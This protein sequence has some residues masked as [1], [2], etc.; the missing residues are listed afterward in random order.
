MT[1]RRRGLGRGLDALLKVETPGVQALPLE[2]LKPNRLQPRERFDGADLDELAESIRA[3]G[4]VQPIVITPR[5]DGDYTIVAGERRWRAARRAGLEQVPV[6]VREISDD[7]EL[8][9]MA[10]V[11]NLQRT[12]LNPMEEAEA[13]SRLQGEF[14]LSQEEVAIRVGKARPSVSNAVRLLRLPD[15]VQELLRAGRLTAGQARPLLSLESGEEQVRLARK[16]ADGGMSARALETRAGGKRKK[17]R[18]ALV[19]PDTAAAAERLTRRLQTRVRIRRRGNAG[20]VQISFHSEEEL[21]R[22]FEML[23]K[24]RDRG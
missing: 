13:Y 14:G 6:A 9:E 16:A 2:R 11:E 17:R 12:D 15:E 5:A 3:Q 4:V 10:L 8:L 23:M 21:M 1:A 18:P 24:A 7:R 19:D 20:T 22:L